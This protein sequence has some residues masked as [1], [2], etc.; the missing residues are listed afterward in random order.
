MDVNGIITVHLK[1]VITGQEITVQLPGAETFI[2][3]LE[4]YLKRLDQSGSTLQS[5]AVPGAPIPL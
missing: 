1:N 3:D 5:E 2:P 4:G